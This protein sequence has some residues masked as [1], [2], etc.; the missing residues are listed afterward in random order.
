MQETVGSLLG[1]AGPPL[2]VAA[3][4]FTFLFRSTK[5]SWN[6][7]PPL[8]RPVERLT[9]WKVIERISVVG[10]VIGVIYLIYDSFYQTTVSV[11]FAYSDPKTAIDNPI[12]LKNNSNMF[13]IRNIKWQCEIVREHFAGASSIENNNVTFTGF[14][15]SIKP[16][17]YL[18]I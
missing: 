15:S 7:D 9:P 11:D 5:H 3:V 8:R 1:I 17:A 6:F 14:I 10:S 12:T 4:I 18:N 13:T 2:F 16:G